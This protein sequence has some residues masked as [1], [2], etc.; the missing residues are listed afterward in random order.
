MEVG[1]AEV[2]AVPL[3][4][5][6]EQRELALVEDR[7]A[8]H[9]VDPRG[10]PELDTERA[11]GPDELPRLVGQHPLRRLLADEEARVRRPAARASTDDGAPHR[12]SDRSREAPLL[13]CAH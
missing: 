10:R 4:V 13:R 9:R 7:L 2:V 1:E 6:E 5:V 3:E 8:R 12:P 11:S